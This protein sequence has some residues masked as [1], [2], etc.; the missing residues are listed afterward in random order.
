[1]EPTSLSLSAAFIL[2]FTYGAGACNIA[3]LPYLGPVFFATESGGLKQ[4]WRR[5]TPF[6]VGRLVGYACAGLLAGVLGDLLA[7]TL[8]QTGLRW[9]LG[10]ATFWVA[11]SLFRAKRGAHKPCATTRKT[12]NR[13]FGLG[14]GLFVM[15]LGMAFNPCAPLS[16]LLLAAATAGSALSGLGLGLAFGA[17][18]VILPT[19]IFSIGVAH[20]ASELRANWGRWRPHLEYA[21]AGMMLLMGVGTWMGW[22]TP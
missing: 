7:D 3:C 9:L 2:G 5:V 11:I 17:G 18:A 12:P 4:A 10:L 22:I 15:G 19:L 13:R 1:M 16:A 8:Q 14:T 20:F 6:S 21:S